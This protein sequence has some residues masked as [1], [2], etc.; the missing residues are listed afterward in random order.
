M[1]PDSLPF[2][3]SPQNFKRTPCTMGRC[4][5]SPVT[6]PCIPCGRHVHMEAS[7]AC[8]EAPCIWSILVWAGERPQATG[9][10]RLTP[11]SSPPVSS[12][13]RL[14]TPLAHRA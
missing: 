3:G 7:F 13:V 2:F 4:Y 5:C 14:H 11:S 12:N 10:R 9:R 6:L 8:T 1:T